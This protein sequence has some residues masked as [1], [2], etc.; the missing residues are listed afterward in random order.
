MGEHRE[1]VREGIGNIKQEKLCEK[2]KP[3]I[4]CIFANVCLAGFNIISK[5]YLNK[6]TSLYVLVTYGQAIGAL[7]TA[8]LAFLF[9]RKND[10]KISLPIVR[11]LFFLGLLG[12]VLG[13]TLYY[14]G[15]EITSPAFASAL[16]NLMPSM[17]FILA[18]LFRMEKIEISKRSSQVKILG[19]VV[20][21]SGAA[22]MTLYK[23]IT[24]ISLHIHHSHQSVTP[25]KVF[26]DKDSIKGSLMLVTSYIS[27]SAFYILQTTTIKMYPAP[28]ALTSLTCLSGAI[29]STIMTAI[30]DHKTSSWKLSWNISLFAPIYSGVVIFGITVYVQT[31]A[32]RLKGPVFMTAFRPLSTLIVAIMGLLILG[33]ALYIGGVIGAMSIIIGLYAT[34]WG[35]EKEKVEKLLEQTTSEQGIE[36]KQEK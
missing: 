5:I 14:A 10:C 6:G 13:R 27:L 9:E 29:L 4:Y 3:Y 30:L 8:L 21:F 26:L 25:S 33:D 7:T 36:I 15:L 31:L 19:T 34:L 11:N 28:I 18:V 20:A 24:V 12:G 22:L 35:K 32:I 17:T 16:C 1:G 23:G 2:L